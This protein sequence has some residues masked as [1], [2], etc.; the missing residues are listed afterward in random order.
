MQEL[1]VTV[2]QKTPS[3]NFTLEKCLTKPD[4]YPNEDDGGNSSYNN[5]SQSHNYGT[6]NYTGGHGMSQ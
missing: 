3:I 6:N 2:K 5:S 4:L 1:F